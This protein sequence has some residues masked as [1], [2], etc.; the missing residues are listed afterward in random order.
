MFIFFN[1]IRKCAHYVFST[2]G[3]TQERVRAP[4]LQSKTLHF[5]TRWHSDCCFMVFIL[6]CFTKMCLDLILNDSYQL[7]HPHKGTHYWFV[8][9]LFLCAFHSQQHRDMKMLLDTSTWCSSRHWVGLNPPGVQSLLPSITR[10]LSVERKLL[11][12][13]TVW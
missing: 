11:L 6:L 1:L 9:W 3:Q 10:L 7:P 4:S 5:W 2:D 13:K 8:A 12:H